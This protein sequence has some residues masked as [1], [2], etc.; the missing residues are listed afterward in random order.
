MGRWRWWVCKCHDHPRC[1]PALGSLRDRPF[2]IT[3][4]F[5]SARSAIA[6]MIPS[7]SNKT[8]YWPGRRRSPSRMSRGNDDLELRDIATRGISIPCGYPRGSSFFWRERKRWRY[9][10]LSS[11]SLFAPT[12]R[13][14]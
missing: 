6:V 4:N 8:I 2:G 3:R 11:H 1:A 9:W 13:P 7:R 5:S 10:Q 12:F 14:W